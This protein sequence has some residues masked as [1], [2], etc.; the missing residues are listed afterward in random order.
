MSCVAADAEWS[1]LLA[2]LS[3]VCCH[4]THVCENSVCKKHTYSD[5]HPL[6]PQP[7]I[8]LLINLFFKRPIS[9]CFPLPAS[10]CPTLAPRLR[11]NCLPI[12]ESIRTWCA[13]LFAGLTISLCLRQRCEEQHQRKD[14][15]AW[16]NAGRHG[17]RWAAESWH[18][19]EKL[20]PTCAG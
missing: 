12:G 13:F 18:E 6:F 5:I 17:R 10:C 2:L 3:E 19:R 9:V 14:A 7:V 4:T 16:R 15:A 20:K 11:P 8:H 1:E